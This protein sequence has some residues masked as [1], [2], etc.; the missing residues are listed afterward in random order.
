MKKPTIIYT[1]T[2]EAP[3][4]A[5]YSLFPVIKAFTKHCDLNVIKE[6]ISLGARIIANFPE[7]LTPE[8]RLKDSLVELGDIVKTPEANVIKLPNV[9]A[10]VPQLQ[11]AIKE[12]QEKNFDIPDYPVELS[13][14]ESKIILEKYNKVIGSAVNPVL[15]EGNSDRR[16][17]KAVKEY[18][19]KHPHKVGPW[20]KDSKTHVSH[21]ECGD[22]YE[23]EKSKIVGKDCLAKIEFTSNGGKKV[24][25]RENIKIQKND[26][27]D[28]ST[29][30]MKELERFFELNIAEAKKQDILLSLHLKATMMKVSDPIIF[31]C[32]VKT[33]Y[34]DVFNKHAQ[35]FSKL[36]INT[37][38]GISDVYDKIKSL[39]QDL[40][41]QVKKDLSD[42]Y[43][44]NPGLAMVD[45]DKG[46]TNLHVPND[47]IIDASMPVVV[48]DSG[49]MWDK[50][51]S[52]NDTKA[53]I[54]DRSYAG[55]YKEI[56]EFCKINGSFDPKTMGN[57]S[58]LGLM[59]KKAEE[60][61]SH[62]NTFQATDDGIVRV[63]SGND[64]I[65]ENKINKDDIWRMCQTKDIAVQNWIEL[66]KDRSKSDNQVSVVFWLDR[67]RGHDSNIISLIEENL[68]KDPN[69]YDLQIMSPVDAMNFSLKEIKK[70]KDTVAATGNVLRDYLTDLFPIL[71]LGTSA[72][73]LSIVPLLRGG[74]L[75]E[76]G[77]GGSAPKHVQ[78]F[79]KENH[80]RWDSLGE[81]LA[82]EI[83][84]ENLAKKTGDKKIDIFSKA[85]TKAN[86]KFL[87]QNK[88]P[89]RKVN[90]I[91]NRGSHFYFSSY[92]AD[93]LAEQSED[94][95]IQDKFQH[96]SRDLKE[97]EDVIIQE[98]ISVQ[99]EKIDIEGYYR[100][101][102]ELISKKMRASETF[103]R[104][105][106]GA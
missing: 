24:I 31:G 13:S 76:T 6:D 84:F 1:E 23:N 62:D 82:L 53:L 100:P 25:H 59:A 57:V 9:S 40:Q 103:N 17:A 79:V 29:M 88:S 28:V 77:A 49:K 2:D 92:W 75:Y 97:N 43:T 44:N 19:K 10:S 69:K 14:D 42:V 16:V 52:L 67:N 74:Y 55:I 21:M 89:S 72:K 98:L 51:G 106:D 5:T 33:Y 91:D 56:I 50:D 36:G 35:T 46:I 65:F 41:D 45:S 3:M 104:I 47:I 7:K 99:G 38:N 58:N 101:N 30:S 60:Y 95:S 37:N 34:K 105:I 18:A 86:I 20:S 96:I 63:I 80:L 8:Q 11:D 54:P 32:A 48:R 73:M 81:F 39:P 66:A 27:I 68:A 93:E 102:I 94:L 87:D 71:E 83:C 26:I 22:F 4:L 12:L 85:L 15:R 78:Q 90:E 61:G 64:I 70:G